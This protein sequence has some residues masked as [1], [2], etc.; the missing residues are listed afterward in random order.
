MN[1]RT[2]LTIT[3]APV[4][5]TTVWAVVDVAPPTPRVAARTCAWSTARTDPP[6]PAVRSG[7]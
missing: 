7:A 2:G 6:G 3:G 5:G 1:T 4:G